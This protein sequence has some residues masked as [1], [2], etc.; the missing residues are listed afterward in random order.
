VELGDVKSQIDQL[1]SRASGAIARVR[2]LV[3]K[4][5]Q[6][7]VDDLQHA[8]VE[9]E[10]LT[11]RAQKRIEEVEADGKQMIQMAG[12]GLMVE[13]VAH[14]LARATEG[15]LQALEALRG[16]DLPSEVK[17]RLETL[18][19]EMKSVS[20][21]LRVL[22]QL[23]V[24]G[25]QRSEVFN[26]AELFDD[27]QEGHA[28]QFERHGVVLKISKP[29]NPVR[30]RLVKGMVIQIIE[31]LL[32]NSLYWIQMRQ[33]REPRL[34]PTIT[35]TI[36]DNPPTVRFEDNGSGIAHDHIEKIFRPFWS[37]KEKSKRRGLG[38]YIAKENAE[39]LGGTLVISNK[40]DP[41]TQRHNEFVLELPESAVVP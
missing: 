7:V 26:L 8:L 36:E 11:A 29:K 9:F 19:S 5:E 22:D 24:S 30:V 2:R 25:R 21:R 20:K 28:P 41:Q 16:R 35:V 37:L 38:L 33:N 10:D 13:V 32:S 39:H 1:K 4:E 6:E 27:I 40:R 23:S 34:V 15:A 3:P 31:N 17:A 12:V 18:R 14:K